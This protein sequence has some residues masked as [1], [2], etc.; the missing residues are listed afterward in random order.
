MGIAYIILAVAS[1][2]VAW[3]WVMQ[4]M[5]VLA[6][7]LTMALAMFLLLAYGWLRASRARSVIDRAGVRRLGKQQGWDVPWEVLQGIKLVEAWGQ[8][9]LVVNPGGKGRHASGFLT[10]G[11]SKPQV[12]VP[13]APDRVGAVR[14]ALVGRGLLG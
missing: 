9:F 6:G 4:N 10:K 2:F 8:T 5:I 13:L 11:A 1:G 12:A 3:H 14:A 7:A